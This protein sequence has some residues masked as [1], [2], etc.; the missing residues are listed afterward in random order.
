M[1]KKIKIIIGSVAAIVVIVL[2]A[3][4]YMYFDGIKATSSKNEEI[5]VTISGGQS[6]VL[7]QLDEAGLLKNKTVASIYLKLNSYDFK[8][9]TYVLN[10]NMDL[11]TICKTI[12]TADFKYLLKDKFTV[13]DGTWIPEYADVVANKLNITKDEVLAKWN[14]KE[15]LQ[16]LIKDY[17]FLDESILDEEIMFPL[18]GYLAPETYFITDQTPTI[19]TITR[20]M[21]DQTDAN[22]EPY[23]EKIENFKINNEKVSVHDFLTF[24]SVV[25]CE[26]LFAE[27]HAK[28]A[29]VFMHR[30]E[31]GMKLQSDVTVNYV[32]QKRK[33]AVTL[34]DLK[35]DSKYN[36][37]K[38]AGIPLGPISSISTDII[39]S[40][41]NYEKVDD[42][43]FF[44][45]KDGTVVYT[46]TYD[47]HLA[48][49]AEA[50]ANGQWLED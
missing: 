20:M 16:S 3:L 34:E 29:G 25:Q 41:V 42:L 36:T 14:D 28:I 50:K 40:C 22:L 15:Y 37:Y 33:V 4:T 5:V 31:T 26:T 47:E 8:A 13:L 11:E 38:Y 27:D 44:A 21:L 1:N 24:A 12:E 43:F 17:W 39:K 23:K 2:A 32:K 45:I 6:S 9:N 48:K 10:K 19:E 7:T 35:I 46:K 49:I 30:L 18:E